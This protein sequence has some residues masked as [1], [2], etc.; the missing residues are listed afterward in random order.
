MCI[1]SEKLPPCWNDET[2][3]NVLFA[4]FRS[5]NAN[6]QDWDSKLA[7]WRNMIELY[8]KESK[9]YKFTLPDLL[10]VFNRNGR[11]PGCLE[12]VI[13]EMFKLNEI[14]SVSEYLEETPSKSWTG[15]ATQVLVKKPIKWT[16]HTVKNSFVERD[17]N[18]EYVHVCSV[19][20]ASKIVLKSLPENCKG[21]VIDMHHLLEVLEWPIE[22]A[23]GLQLV[24][25][26]LVCE[27][28]ADIKEV[29]FS[30][31]P[32]KALTL[33]LIK[34]NTKTVKPISDVDVS[35][36]ILEENEK[37][38][39]KN[40]EKQ[41]A[42]VNRIR[43][44]AKNCLK[45]GHRQMAKSLLIKKKELEKQLTKKCN[46]LQNVHVL[47]SKVKDVED[48]AEILSSYKLALTS[49]QN[50]FKKT[51]LTEDGVADTMLSLG[52]VLDTHED[53]QASL[54][55]PIKEE[56]YSELEEELA[57]LLSMDMKEKEQTENKQDKT[58]N[59]K[60]EKP[61]DDSKKTAAYALETVEL[62]KKFQ[63]LK[64]PEVPTSDSNQI[65]NKLSL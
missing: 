7:F 14:K 39:T 61:I 57:E 52:D 8:C 41:E 51:G 62:E 43:E 44:Q 18:Q 6:P 16:F 56:N 37:I 48:D 21:K 30:E 49:L 28:K 5:R 45:T 24:L 65:K 38:L 15:W 4:P 9:C 20:I 13:N 31:E 59:D 64:L 27:E 33:K 50:T 63:N 19:D 25:H 58:Q 35:I 23:N 29:G 54:S 22:K 3:M 1:P 55:Q 26:K 17:K 12:V 47:L 36:H 32:E 34:I 2:R 46:A 10:K 53:I 60:V 40:I 42:E 11:S